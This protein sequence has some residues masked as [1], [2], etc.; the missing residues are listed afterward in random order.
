MPVALYISGF[1]LFQ[2]NPDTFTG[3]A[4]LLSSFSASE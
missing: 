1:F 2:D 3:F 4:Q